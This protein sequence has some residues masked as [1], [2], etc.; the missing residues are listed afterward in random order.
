MEELSI[1][2][3]GAGAMGKGIAEVAA[4]RGVKTTLV[5]ATAGPLDGVRASLEGSLDRAVKR[6]K[7]DAAGRDG[8]LSRI[9]FTSDRTSVA[10]CDLVIESVIEDLAVKQ[11]LLAEI[12]RA[13]PRDAVFATNTSSLRVAQ[14]G[15][16]LKRTDRL[17]GV[18]FFSPVPAMKLVEIAPTRLTAPFAVER[19]QDLVQLLGKTPVLVGDSSGYIV[20]RLL[21]PYLLDGIAALEAGV[22]S[23]EDID[24]A[25]RLGCGHPM[26]PLAL[27]DAIG[28]DVVYAMARTLYVELHDHRYS[29][30][31][32]LRRLVV[33]GSLGKKTGM[34]V[35]NYRMD[36]PVENPDLRP[37]IG[38]PGEEHGGHA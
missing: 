11:E 23:A 2:I 14:I 37:H 22:A 5:K 1:A 26:G 3:L 9:T 18:H 13:A 8:A 38:E 34:G 33:L 28:L 29:P 15:E 19:A 35:Y 30:P 6:G 32:L 27:A 31:A 4:V 12:E 36:P 16:R 17:L 20:N 24:T 21:V 10:E 7:L 25:M